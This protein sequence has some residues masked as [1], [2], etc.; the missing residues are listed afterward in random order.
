M[1]TKGQKGAI[2]GLAGL[3]GALAVIWGLV[4]QVAEVLPYAPRDG[5]LQLAG[6]VR[7]LQ[8][9]D[10][11]D[12]KLINRRL[13]YDNLEA[14]KPYLDAGQPVPALI[15]RDWIELEEEA[16]QLE[17]ELNRLEQ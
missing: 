5:F 3:I 6:D 8:K 15:L 2:M 13:R 17:R 10:V 1:L 11:I 16:H 12:R 9:Q 14:Q 4:G 7:E